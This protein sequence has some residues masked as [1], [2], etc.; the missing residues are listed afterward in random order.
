MKY[1]GSKRRVAKEIIPI[2]LKDYKD[3]QYFYD[4]F[5]GG[6]NLIDKIPNTINRVANDLNEYIIELVKKLQT[7][8]LPEK[9]I[10]I[11]QYEQIKNNQSI[12]PKYYLGY[13]GYQLT[14]SSQWFGSYRRDNIGKR[15]YSLEA[16]NNIK[17]QTPLLQGIELYNTSY[18]NVP[19]NLNSIIYCDIPYKN[20]SG[21][22][23]GDFDY[24]KFYT[25][26]I[27]KHN[28][29]HKVFISE[30]NMPEDKF[31]CIWSKEIVSS[32]TPENNGKKGIEKLFI[33][34]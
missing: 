14:Y 25:W 8:W 3:G 16:Y 11:I 17:K 4:L 6:F 31:K 18:E 26:C 15:D 9:E 2:M 30:Y 20:T 13:I 27:E 10:S 29:G 1:M 7:G 21:Y 34:R 28:E 19:L 32:L 22:I 12:Y 5:A 24:D 23:T 33:V